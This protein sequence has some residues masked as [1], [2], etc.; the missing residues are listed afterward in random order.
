LGLGSPVPSVGWLDDRRLLVIVDG[1]VQSG[2]GSTTTS[3]LAIYDVQTK[4]LTDA[5]VGETSCFAL[6]LDRQNIVTDRTGFS[7]PLYES[8]SSQLGGQVSFTPIPSSENGGIESVALDSTGAHL[9]VVQA[10]RDL[11][12]GVVGRQQ[13]AFE[14]KGSAWALV[15]TSPMPFVGEGPVAQRVVWLR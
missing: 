3:S 1:M 13:Q 7:P 10:V 6:S 11:N 12:G 9:L 2:G 14:K 4:K 8:S 5:R 15:L